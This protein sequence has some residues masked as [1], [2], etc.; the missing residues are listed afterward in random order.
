MAT[1]KTPLYALEHPAAPRMYYRMEPHPHLVR[2]EFASLAPSTP[3]G[4]N[5]ILDR[6]A[7]LAA[8]GLENELV[9]LDA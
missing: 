7:V 9:R 5:W 2:R 8:Q 6:S 1:L 4:L 3:D